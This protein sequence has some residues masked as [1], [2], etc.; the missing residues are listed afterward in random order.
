[1]EKLSMRC[2]KNGKITFYRK[3]QLKTLNIY[4]I[5]TGNN[6]VVKSK[7]EGGFQQNLLVRQTLLKFAYKQ[8]LF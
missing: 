4:F 8:N 6:W 7:N 5:V 3:L 1:M 2:K